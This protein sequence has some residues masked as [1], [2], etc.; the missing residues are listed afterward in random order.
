MLR[1]PA[2]LVFII[3][4]FLL[5]IPLA[6][7]Y[8]FARNYVEASNAI[9]NG[10][11][12]FTMSFG[13]MS[14]VFFMLIMPLC[15]ARLGVK[16][17]LLVGMGAW[18]LR[19]GLF[20]YAAADHVMWM[21]LLGIILHGVCYDFFF[22]TGMIYADKRA[23]AEIR[24]QA[25]GF[26]V[27]VTQGLGLGIGAKLFAAHVTMNTT[28]AGADWAKIWLYPAVFAGLVMTLFFLFFWDRVDR[29]VDEGEV[30]EATAAITEP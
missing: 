12:T 28:A 2:Y 23:P 18:V 16:W 24:N 25:Q 27:L 5:C 7:Y 6:G 21:I 11:A 9:V 22:V 15:F 29:D 10:S 14:E 8:A 3:C 26:L 1:S 19:Y 13:Q 30:A 20:S 17:M 4:S